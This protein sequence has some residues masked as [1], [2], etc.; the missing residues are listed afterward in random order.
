MINWIFTEKKQEAPKAN[1]CTSCIVS[2]LQHAMQIT[3]CC[4]HT[5]TY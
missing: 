5:Y 1:S 2:V 4:I 3:H